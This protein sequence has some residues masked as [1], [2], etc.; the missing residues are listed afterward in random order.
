[1]NR[2]KK[3][4]SFASTTKS[5]VICKEYDSS[6][7][8]E[9]ND[10]EE[11]KEEE[12]EGESEAEQPEEPA[13]DLPEQEDANHATGPSDWADVMNKLLNTNVKSSN[14]ILSK[15]KKD[16]FIFVDEDKKKPVKKNDK[17]AFEVVREDGAT[18]VVTPETSSEPS[19]T[20]EEKVEASKKTK[21]KI[22]A[23]LVCKKAIDWERSKEM[24]LNAIAI[25]GVVQ[26]FNAVNQQHETLRKEL[27]AAGPS[28]TKKDKVMAS[29]TK[30]KFLEKLN[31]FD[32][33]SSD[34]E[35]EMEPDEE[36]EKAVRKLE[37]KKRKKQQMQGKKKL[38]L[39]KVFSDQSLTKE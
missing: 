19:K 1:M 32:D 10:E 5:R 18:D 14:F 39:K 8:E 17:D 21:R 9:E 34:E 20:S 2:N 26:L 15:A 30:D 6:S 28:E 3:A 27:K 22:V 35:A 36:V 23:K 31:Q 38:D 37:G 7:E 33:K 11:L 16:R 13:E 25:R 29:F 4:V 12:S 24:R